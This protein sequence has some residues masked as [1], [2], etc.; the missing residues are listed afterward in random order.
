MAGHLVQIAKD[1]QNTR[2]AGHDNQAHNVPP[3]LGTTHNIHFRQLTCLATISYEPLK[4]GELEVALD[5]YL[6][7]NSSQF[8][9]DSKLAP[10]YSSRAR[11]AGSPMKKEVDIVGDKLKVAKRRAT[12]AIE[13]VLNE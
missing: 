8:A 9:S 6:G 5:E 12:K 13:D 7:A 1:P 10:F 3:P 2:C 4:K 11:S